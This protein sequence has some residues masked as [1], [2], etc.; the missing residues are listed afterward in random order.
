[1]ANLNNTHPVTSTGRYIAF[2]R[3]AAE[4]LKMD[5]LLTLAA[6]MFRTDY[7]TGISNATQQTLANALALSEKTVRTHLDHIEQ[8]GFITVRRGGEVDDQGN[9]RR[10]NTYLVTLP[11]RDF[12]FV[13]APL[14]AQPFDPEVV[15]EGDQMKMRAFL[16]QCKTQCLNNTN[17]CRYSQREMAARVRT[18]RPTLSRFF[19]YGYTTG[20]LCP[21]EKG[22][23]RVMPSYLNTDV[24]DGEELFWFPP[25][26]YERCPNWASGYRAVYRAIFDFCLARGMS[27]PP[28]FHEPVATIFDRVCLCLDRDEARNLLPVRTTDERIGQG[29]IRR[30]TD[31]LLDNLDDDADDLR[32]TLGPD[33]EVFSLN[34]FVERICHRHHTLRPVRAMAEEGFDTV[35]I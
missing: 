35:R 4:R 27:C 20:L 7:T 5:E 13:N 2:P 6:L 29:L 28:Y 15:P 32:D 11:E 22:G 33:M 23:F 19:N 10:R 8:A 25:S 3:S 1:M 21:D 12:I 17:L 26:E 30:K 18:S 24:R 14:F 31:E 16:I 34:Y 9:P